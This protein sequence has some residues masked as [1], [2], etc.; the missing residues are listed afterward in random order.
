ML[1]AA[2]VVQQGALVMGRSRVDLAPLA[3]FAQQRGLTVSFRRFSATTN[4]PLPGQPVVLGA[5]HFERAPRSLPE[6]LAR[7][8]RRLDEGDFTQAL[9]ALQDLISSDP[10]RKM[11]E[12]VALL[13]KTID[14]QTTALDDPDQLMSVRSFPLAM[15][16][17]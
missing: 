9:D 8:E 1:Q 7:L 10:K 17:W 6:R 3:A 16:S 5:K 2:G 15:Q 11:K 4:E 12:R 14:T 13:L